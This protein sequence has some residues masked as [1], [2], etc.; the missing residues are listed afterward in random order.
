MDDGGCWA[1][2]EPARPALRRCVAIEP[3]E[4]AD[5]YWSREP[6]LAA[7]RP[8]AFDDLFSLAA[9]DELISRRGLRAPF[10]R[11][12]RD[13]KVVDAARF[14]GSGGA[15]AEIADQ[16]RDD[17]VAELFAEG[18]TLVLQGLHR[19]WPPLAD[20]AAQ[21]A[22]DLGHPVQVNAYVTPPSNR[23]FAAHYDVHD[24]FVMQVAGGKRWK[25]HPPVLTDPLRGQPWNDHAGAVAE[26][27]RAEPLIDAVLTPGHRLYLPRGYLHS[28]QALG[29]VSVHLT[30]GVR[31]VTRYA[32]VEEL[33]KL[34]AEAPG[35][36][37]SLPLGTD[38]AD[39]EQVA[40]HLAGTVATLRD[41]LAT[42]DP[43]TVADRLRARTW[44]Q[45]RPGPV[46]PLAQAAA[47]ADLDQQSVVRRRP[48]LRHR[49][50]ARG[51]TVVLQLADRQIR[52]P[53]VTEPALKALLTGRPIRV[54]ELT[55]LDATDRLALARRL[56]R[57]AVC[58][59]SAQ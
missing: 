10:L 57:E 43:A 25:I 58:V 13:G 49:L 36:R 26:Q 12:A 39:P 32:L 22:A 11:V 44:P 59:P 18:C 28:A 21:L 5:R 33:L 20:F 1:A 56:L 3:V 42:A 27:A 40:P 17:K 2:E 48:Q 52:F 24:V 8:E 29:E 47:V 35:L 23:G 31:P 51:D 30:V 14:T 34:A 45:S 55:G 19:T 4:F 37:G 9:V 53:A 6:L 38:V 41:W 46:P 15:G 50:E 7:G 54:G 16:V